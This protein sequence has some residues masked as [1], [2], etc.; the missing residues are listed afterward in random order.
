MTQDPPKAIPSTG[1]VRLPSKGFW[2]GA[3]GH[4]SL[5]RQEM[6]KERRER[7][8][9]V[10][11]PLPPK[12]RDHAPGHKPLSF[13]P[14]NRGAHAR[15]RRLAWVS[16]AEMQSLIGDEPCPRSSS[17]GLWGPGRPSGPV[18]WG[19]AWAPDRL[20]AGTSETRA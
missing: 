6:D 10:P 4:D 18:S 19:L 20:P 2:R 5:V 1:R 7:R 8:K 9:Q 17:C 15:R 14:S 16:G 3:R 13:N 12:A 11:G